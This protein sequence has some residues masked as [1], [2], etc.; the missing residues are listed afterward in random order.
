M[1]YKIQ[2]EQ[3]FQVLASNFSIGPSNE[4]YTLQIS[5]D[6]VNYSD[7][8]S[9]G[10]N[11]TRMVTGVANGS[12]YRLSGNASLV[13]VNWNKHCND[14]GGSGSGAQG[15]QGLEGP[16]GYQGATGAQGPAGSGSQGG[17]CTILNSVSALPINASWVEYADN[18]FYKV[19]ETPSGDGDY[20][21]HYNGTFAGLTIES[22]V[23]TGSSYG[24]TD[25][26][27]GVWAKDGVTAWVEGGKLYWDSPYII[28]MFDAYGTGSD[29]EGYSETAAAN[30]S[31]VAALAG[32][33]GVYQV[34]NNKWEH[35]GIQGPQGPAG[36]GEGGDNTILA[37]VSALP[38]EYI[39]GTW[40]EWADDSYTIARE[41]CTNDGDYLI[42]WNNNE[43]YTGVHC[44]NGAI[45]NSGYG[46]VLGSDGLWHNQNNPD[47]IAYSEDGKLYWIGL[48]SNISMLDAYETGSDKEGNTSAVYGPSDATGSVRATSGGAY[49]A[50]SNAW[51]PLVHSDGGVVNIWRGTAADYANL[52]S[53]DANTLY[54][55]L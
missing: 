9:V 33:Q 27:G 34:V 16:Q 6:G 23:I 45:D 15:P 55:I 39:F 11:V 43:N 3:P 18:T 4:G 21:L 40:E 12:F 41:T 44:S 13:T 14:G 7:L 49:Q 46:M 20:L 52:P 22:G 31:S 48:P 54:I 26:G 8:F 25:E 42:H 51:T 32:Q 24:M 5:S 47:I 29:L 53:T 28:T 19:R 50:L 1:I 2:G 38:S 10:A 17:D 36:G 30:E 37:P 35:V